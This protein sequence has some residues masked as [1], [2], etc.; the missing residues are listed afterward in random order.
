MDKE[1][2][3]IN[4]ATWKKPITISAPKYDQ[5]SEAILA[6][7]GSEPI[8]FSDLVKLVEKEL[9]N[10]DGSVSWYT[11]SVSRELEMRGKLVRH[12]K[13]VRYSRPN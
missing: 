5:V 2:V 12:A 6:V 8:R 9:P 10:F 3:A 13:P 1:R 4:G 7:L 11:V